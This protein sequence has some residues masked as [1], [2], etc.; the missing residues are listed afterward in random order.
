MAYGSQIRS[1]SALL[2]PDRSAAT[3]AVNAASGTKV[4]PARRGRR[5]RAGA[6]TGPTHSRSAAR[7]AQTQYPYGRSA[8][9]PW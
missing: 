1:T 9:Q 4:M 2:S 7:S 5:S 6:T 8:A 3:I